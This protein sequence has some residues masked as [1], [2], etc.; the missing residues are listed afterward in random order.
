MRISRHGDTGARIQW[1]H[2]EGLTNALKYAPGGRALVAVEYGPS[3]LDI[4]IDD[5]RGPG[6]APALE[7][8]HEGRGLVGMRERVAMFRGTFEAKP[9]PTGFRVTAH[10]PADEAVPAS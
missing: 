4:A 2:Q 10:L 1:P 5:A 6:T 3:G 8:D 9:T 7:A